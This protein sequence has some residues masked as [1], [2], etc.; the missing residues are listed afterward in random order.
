MN[1]LTII[2]LTANEISPGFARNT[3]EHF[4][5]AA[6]DLPVITV[7]KK[8]WSSSYGKSL[9]FDTPRSHVN[10]YREALEGVKLAE[11]KY[12]AIAE[13]DVLYSPEHFKK[14]P[15]RDGVFAYNIACWSIYTWSDP[16][17]FSYTGRR[18]HGMLICERDLYIKVFEERFA[19]FT[20][21][22]EINHAI[23]AEPGKYERQLGVTEQQTE[24]FY[25]DP[26]NVMFTHPKGL[27]MNTLGTRKRL[28][29]IRALEIPYWGR[30][31][32]VVK[33]YE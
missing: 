21:D 32:E 4:L 18:N 24:T 33:L 15:S 1:D 2:Y 20:D 27:S 6:N 9:V 8:L 16:A 13:D 10:I 23:W 3:L 25:T 5:L 14:R 28:A 26:S 7:S 12:I 22:S 31:E 19:K 17:I 29:P 30:A 11:T